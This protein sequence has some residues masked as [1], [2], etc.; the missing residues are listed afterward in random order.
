MVN[1][2]GSVP[3]GLR[4]ITDSEWNRFPE[5]MQERFEGFYE[6]KN[7]GASTLPDQPPT[8]IQGYILRKIYEDETNGKIHLGHYN[9]EQTIDRNIY[10]FLKMCLSTKVMYSVPFPIK[11]KETITPEQWNEVNPLVQQELNDFYKY[12]HKIDN[13]NFYRPAQYKLKESVQ[14]GK[15]SDP[16]KTTEHDIK[17]LWQDCVF[18]K[19]ED[20]IKLYLPFPIELKETITTEEWNRL[21]TDVAGSWGVFINTLMK[22]IILT[23][24][25]LNI[26]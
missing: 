23:S 15:H 9:P 7:I 24:I 26:N 16:G 13:P 2:N 10:A 17:T 21:T 25:A 19:G 3:I 20:D 11:L 12:F 1:H 18:G 22:L 14:Q 8:R 4:K 6:K 5:D